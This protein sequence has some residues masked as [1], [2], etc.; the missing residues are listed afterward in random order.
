M[1][2]LRSLCEV[3]GLDERITSL[4]E[5]GEQVKGILE[6]ELDSV[7]RLRVARMILH[8]PSVSRGC[9][10]PLPELKPPMPLG[11]GTCGSDLR[12]HRS[13]GLKAA[14][15]LWYAILRWCCPAPANTFF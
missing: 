4:F 10:A 12:H 6:S 2:N 1:L 13:P 5:G 15:A 8:N 14:S 3:V 7:G 11:T 9:V